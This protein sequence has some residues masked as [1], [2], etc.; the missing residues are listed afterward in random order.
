[1]LSVASP[2]EADRR[3]WLGQIDGDDN[4]REFGRPRGQDE[5]GPWI[6][7]AYDCRTLTVMR[8]ILTGQ[9]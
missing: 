2:A 1:M 6:S 3:A 8:S 5:K 4:G 7:T 9:L